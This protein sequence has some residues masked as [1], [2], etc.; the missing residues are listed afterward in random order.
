MYEYTLIQTIF[1]D[2]TNVEELRDKF[3]YK[4]RRI[5]DRAGEYL[6]ISN[7]DVWMCDPDVYFKSNV[8]VNT[9]SFSNQITFS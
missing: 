1:T 5:A 9:L 6:K 8:D 2:E 3:N 7:R 4:Y